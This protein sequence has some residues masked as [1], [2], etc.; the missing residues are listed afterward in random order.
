[1]NWNVVLVGG[2]VKTSGSGFGKFFF[3]LLLLGSDK[4]G[5]QKKVKTYHGCVIAVDRPCV[6]CYQASIHK[7]IFDML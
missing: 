5:T 7:C 1:M 4:R 3:L 2:R 6:L